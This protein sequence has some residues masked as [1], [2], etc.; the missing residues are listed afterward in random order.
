M[1]TPK[2][3]PLIIISIITSSLGLLMVLPTL[4]LLCLVAEN[5]QNPNEWLFT[6]AMVSLPVIGFTLLAGYFVALFMKRHSAIFWVFSSLFNFA[7]SGLSLYFLFYQ[8]ASLNNKH[9][10]ATELQYAGYV[11]LFMIWTL[12]VALSSL[13]YARF[14]RA[15]GFKKLP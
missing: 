7:L 2:T 8:F 10:Y 3:A 15:F 12:F 4:L 9:Y 13:Y 6:A 11:C 14:A 5:K 1:K